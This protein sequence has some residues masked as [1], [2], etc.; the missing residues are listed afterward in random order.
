MLKKLAG[1]AMVKKFINNRSSKRRG[2]ARSGS[3]S[4]TRPGSPTGNIDSPRSDS[5]FGIRNP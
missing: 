4:T 5:T 2:R 3:Q 1:L